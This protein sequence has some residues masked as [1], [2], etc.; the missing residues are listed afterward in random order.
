MARLLLLDDDPV[1]LRVL[2][3]MCHQDDHETVTS[4]SVK[5]ALKI[6]ET[7]PNID[8]V[9]AD[10]YMPN[11]TGVDL[12]R[13]VQKTHNLKDI[14]IILCTSS[15][16]QQ[17]LAEALK[18]GARDFIVKP[19][20]AEVLLSK[21]QKALRSGRKTVLVVEDEGLV[22]DRLKL[23]LEM[24]G[25]RVNAVATAEEALE[26]LVKSRVDVIVADIG[27]VGMTGVELARLVKRRLPKLPV[28]LVTGLPEKITRD[29][30]ASCG[31]DGFLCKPFRNTDIS[32][33]IHSLLAPSVKTKSI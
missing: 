3:G 23:I 29:M 4:S 33:T 24:E 2:Q 16:D 32:N 17:T 30:T 13:T 28:L 5:Q 27:L 26:Q 9:I 15:G 22:R 7:D 21:V 12:V 11:A 1:I 25:F 6:L 8:L 19:F 10:I 14:P 20:T 18:A 31:A